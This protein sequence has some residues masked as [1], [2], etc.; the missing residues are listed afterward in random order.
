METEVARCDRTP[1]AD[2]ATLV[3]VFLVFNLV[4]T[5]FYFVAGIVLLEKG[6]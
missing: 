4:I 3:P 5:T 6:E 1:Q 2:A